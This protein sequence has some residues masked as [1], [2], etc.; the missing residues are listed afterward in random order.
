LAEVGSEVDG[1][2]ARVFGAGTRLVIFAPGLTWDDE[3]GRDRKARLDGCRGIL[4]E[5]DVLRRWELLWGV[6]G[7]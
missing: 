2:G 4:A 3:G 5:W 6:V 7:V 1:V